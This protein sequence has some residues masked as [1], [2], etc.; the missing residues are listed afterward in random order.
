M[1]ITFANKNQ[2]HARNVKRTSDMALLLTELIE[3]FTILD[4]LIDCEFP[5]ANEL[6]Y[7]CFFHSLITCVHDCHRH[8]IAI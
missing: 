2:K 6:R 7:D 5:L 4:M 1:E 8:F 3:S